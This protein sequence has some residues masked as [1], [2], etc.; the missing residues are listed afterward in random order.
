MY[1]VV[2][3]LWSTAKLSVRRGD[4]AATSAGNVAI[5]A[6]GW[7]GAR[8]N[9][10]LFLDLIAKFT[11]A[12]GTPSN[13]VDFFN[14]ATQIWSTAQLNVA[15]HYI[16]AVSVKNFAILAGGMLSGAIAPVLPPSCA[17]TWQSCNAFLD[18]IIRSGFSWCWS[19]FSCQFLVE[20]PFSELLLQAKYILTL[21]IYTMLKLGFG[22]HP[23]SA[24]LDGRYQSHHLIVRP[25]LLEE[26]SKIQV[27]EGLL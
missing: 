11:L 17:R 9:L 16:A 8:C 5:F 20:F 14:G 26:G 3:G 24:H 13:A 18:F 15:R 7:S 6:G 2:T 4:L 23:S 22:Q 25:C 12:L 19:D 10:A 21:L 1:N 27:I